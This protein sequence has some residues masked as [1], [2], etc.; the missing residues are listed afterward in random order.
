MDCGARPNDHETF[1]RPLHIR[2]R[3]L[4]ASQAAKR[5][6]EMPQIDRAYVAIALFLLII[7]ELLGFYMGM[8]ATTPG[9][10]CTSRSCWSAS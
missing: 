7:G 9:A 3:R 1:V 2:P 8:R 4:A 6:T 10:R 5:R